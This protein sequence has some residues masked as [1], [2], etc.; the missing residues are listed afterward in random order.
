MAEIDMS[1]LHMPG[2]YNKLSK[3]TILPNT[4]VT[5]TFPMTLTWALSRFF[6]RSEPTKDMDVVETPV[7]GVED[8]LDVKEAGK[9]K[10]RGRETENDD[11][12]ANPDFDDV[13]IHDYAVRVHLPMEENSETEQGRTLHR[14]ERARARG[15]GDSRF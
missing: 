12:F 4:K 1:F 7:Y 14:K 2:T 8:I 3:V 6:R 5:S 9:Q 15:R 13:E 11:P 10:E